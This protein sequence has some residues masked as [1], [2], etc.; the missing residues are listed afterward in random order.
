MVIRLV[1]RR[2]AGISRCRGYFRILTEIISSELDS[3]VDRCASS[4]PWETERTCL[5]M[6]SAYF[7]NSKLS[8]FT[9][10]RNISCQAK[11]GFQASMY[12]V[13]LF[14]HSQKFEILL[15]ENFKFLSVCMSDHCSSIPGPICLKFEKSLEPSDLAFIRKTPGKAGFSK[16]VNL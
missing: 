10:Q 3:I 12:F 9:L 7:E 5:R 14:V 11:M 1:R 4:F 8:G 15:D 2:S 16:L 6:F 13:C